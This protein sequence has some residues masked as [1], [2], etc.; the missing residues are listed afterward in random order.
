MRVNKEVSVL[1]T[2]SICFAVILLAATLPVSAAPTPLAIA[3]EEFDGHSRTERIRYAKGV[4]GAVNSIK[5]GLPLLKPSEA[6]WI[7][8][9]QD[10]IDKLTDVNSKI[11]RSAKLYI[12]SPEYQHQQL[13]VSLSNIRDGLE[14]VLSSNLNSKEA[15][16]REMFC[17]AAVSFSL[18][19]RDLESTI[20]VTQNSG[21]LSLKAFEV[22]GKKVDAELFANVL[23]RIS[24][25]IQARI[26]IPYLSGDKFT[27]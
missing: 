5:A 12:L 6:E 4:L 22:S 23:G 21:R 18:N 25:N 3:F 17:W 7:K 2:K 13:E 9:E 20:Q 1:K 16:Q 24:T 14:C 10:E 19:N 15:T 8:R 27:K 26:I 11:D